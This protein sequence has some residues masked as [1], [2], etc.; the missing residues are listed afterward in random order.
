LVE[1]EPFEAS[2]SETERANEYG[3]ESDEY[4][5]CP[6]CNKGLDYW[7]ALKSGVVYA[8]ERGIDLHMLVEHGIADKYCPKGS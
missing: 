7:E 4:W 5:H 8:T 1:L 6:Y 2:K 3:V